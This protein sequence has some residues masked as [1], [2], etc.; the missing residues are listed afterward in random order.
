MP[1]S[2]LVLAQ[3]SVKITNS[4]EPAP[5]AGARISKGGFPKWPTVYQNLICKNN[6]SRCQSV[7]TRPGP[8]QGTLLTGPKRKFHVKCVGI[9][10]QLHC[11]QVRAKFPSCP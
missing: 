11:S 2:S 8:P 7:G 3:A 6:F 9:W 4:T 10:K 1:T 5:D